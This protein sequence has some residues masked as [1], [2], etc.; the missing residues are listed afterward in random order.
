MHSEQ[1]RFEDSFVHADLHAS[2]IRIVPRD[3]VEEATADF[4]ILFPHEPVH[5]TPMGCPHLCLYTDSAP[6][7]LIAE[8]IG[9]HLQAVEHKQ[10]NF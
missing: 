2:R 3:E 5:V 8:L 6:A 4:R 1:H 9:E 10:P 7:S